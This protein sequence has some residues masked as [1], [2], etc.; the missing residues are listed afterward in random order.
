MRQ[1][2]VIID[3]V[4][5][6]VNDPIDAAPFM[7]LLLPA[8]DKAC[9]VISDPEARGVAQRTQAAMQKLNVLVEKEKLRQKFIDLDA[10]VKAIKAKVTVNEKSEYEETF[11]RHVGQLCCSL[12]SIRAFDEESWKE[13]EKFLVVL[14]SAK[15]ILLHSFSFSL[16]YQLK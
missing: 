13:I 7:G 16:S 5:R 14:D 6:L 10:V 9:E 8:L 3:N 4:A 12:M 1:A 2:A 11:V 15:G